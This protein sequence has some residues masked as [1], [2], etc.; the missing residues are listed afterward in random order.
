MKRRS[1]S[2]PPRGAG[3]AAGGEA[4]RDGLRTAA[5]RLIR[6]AGDAGE[7]T[8]RR[9]VGEAGASLN[10]VN[11]HYGSKEALVR[12]AVRDVVA[13]WFRAGGL[14]PEGLRGRGPAAVAGLAADFLFAE[15]V[16]ARLALDAELAERGAGPSLTREALEGLAHELRDAEPGLPEREARLRAWVVLSAVHQV[17]L[18][19]EGCREWLGA[20]P[21]DPVAR[22]ALVGRLVSLVQGPA[23]GPRGRT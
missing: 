7:V 12:E 15:P 6:Q 11:Y 18:R 17:F 23:T 10:A 13:D 22:R 3:A 9:V 8:I 1:K 5:R 14:G 2:R 19:P 20:D 21:A 4:T 16:A